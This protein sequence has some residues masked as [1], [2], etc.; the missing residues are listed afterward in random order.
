MILKIGGKE[1][2]LK[3]FV[4]NDYIELKDNGVDFEELKKG[5]FEFKALRALIFQAVKRAGGDVPIEWVGDNI[6]TD[7]IPKISE[8]I[9][10]FFNPKESQSTKTT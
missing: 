1:F 2:E 4:L 10:N 9:G 6:T 5:Q 8:V 7:D 3:P